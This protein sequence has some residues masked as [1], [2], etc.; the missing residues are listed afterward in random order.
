MPAFRIRSTASV[1][2]TSRSRTS[3]AKTRASSR[4][5]SRRPRSPSASATAAAGDK[6]LG[7]LPTKAGGRDDFGRPGSE[8][9]R[10]QKVDAGFARP[11]GRSGGGKLARSETV[12]VRLDPKLRYFAELAA[13]KQRRTLSSFIEWAIE[14]SLNEVHFSDFGQSYSMASELSELWDVDEADRFAKLALSHPDMLLHDEQVLWKLIR[15]NRYVWKGHYDRDTKRFTWE[16]RQEDLVFERLRQ[17]WDAFRSVAFENANKAHLPA[18]KE[19][20]DETSF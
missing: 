16:V 1:F 12:T 13:R 5:A 15:E 8:Y 3:A 14:Q 4:R 20:E 17:F 9:S 10:C 7:K 19:F 6:D 2:E 18:W 11:K